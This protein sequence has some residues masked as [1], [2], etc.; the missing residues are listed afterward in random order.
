MSTTRSRGTRLGALAAVAVMALSACGGGSIEEETKANEDKAAAAGAN[1]PDMKDIDVGKL[2]WS[3]LSA[4]TSALADA[5]VKAAPKKAADGS[6]MKWSSQNQAN[7]A[8]AVSVKQ[9][10]SPFWPLPPSPF[11]AASPMTSPPPPWARPP[12]SSAPR[13]MSRPARSAPSPAVP[14]TTTRS[15]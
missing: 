3:L 11:R 12:P 2:D 9:S 4:D 6:D 15:S 7:G 8:A 1:D 13:S 10:V 14:T 5:K